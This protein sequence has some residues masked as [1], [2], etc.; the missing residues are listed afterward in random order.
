LGLDVIVPEATLGN[1]DPHLIA[2][3][4][5]HIEAPFCRLDMTD[6]LLLGYLQSLAVRGLA[7]HV[8]DSFVR[9][10]AVVLVDALNLDRALRRGTSETV[11]DASIK[12]EHEALCVLSAHGM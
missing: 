5:Q 12:T 6:G 10:L 4:P 2:L 3:R 8:C 11:N 9:V 7:R 1:L